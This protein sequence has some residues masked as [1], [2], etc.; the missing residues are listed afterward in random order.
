M[1]ITGRIIV[2]AIAFGGWLTSAAGAAENVLQQLERAIRSRVSH[3]AA[4]AP[5]RAAAPG[6]NQVP[7]QPADSAAPSLGEDAKQSG[8]QPQSAGYLGAV[9]DDTNDRG[10]GVRVIEVRPG[11]PAEKAGLK[12]Q[13]LITG[14]AGTRVRELAD[15]ASILSLFA[16]GDTITLDVRRGEQ[17]QQIKVTLGTRPAAASQ[18]PAQPVPPPAALPQPPSDPTKPPQ[19]PPTGPVLKLP[20]L[21][22]P[23]EPA[24]RPAAETKPAAQPFD[25]AEVKSLLV[26]LQQRIEKLEARIARLEKAL[27]EPQDKR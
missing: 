25:M 27:A 11:S 13:D 22:Q 19:A 2:C 4:S 5:H 10:R 15:M 14:V 26:E 9:A 18:P 7:A 20:D 23:V 17:T 6:G 8:Q 16:P 1:T 3:E 24:V 12:P 21:P